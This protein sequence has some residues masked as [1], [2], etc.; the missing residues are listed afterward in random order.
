MKMITTTLS[1]LATAGIATAAVINVPGQH[2]TIQSGLNA[3]NTCDTVSV[4]AGLWWS[5]LPSG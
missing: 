5:Y 2:P 3:A 4:A 1:L